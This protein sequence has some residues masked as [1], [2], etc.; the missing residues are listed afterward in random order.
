MHEGI[1]IAASAGIKQ[2]KKMEVIANNLANVNSTGYKKDRLAFKEL[3]PPFPPDTE[4][5]N[6]KNA[7]LPSNKSNKNV[8][9]V[10]VTDQYTDH[11]P[12]IFKQTNSELDMALDGDGYFSISTAEGVLYTRNGNFRLDTE[13]QLVNQKGEPVLNEQGEPIVITA[14]GS[15]IS[16]DANGNIFVGSGLANAN[17][18][19]IKMVNFENKQTLEK[20]GDG[21]FYQSDKE[22][23]EKPIDNTKLRQGFLEGSN[24]TAVEEMTN[25][26]STLRLFETYQ[27]MIQSIDSMD[28]QSVNK[29]GRIG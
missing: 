11:K 15:D 4:M 2:G 25:M 10:A 24:V 8:S 22:A 9:Y 20:I 5:E 12:G 14:Q 18:G 26:I 16:I 17:I 1:Y 29:I 27:K 7:L 19:K 23:V 21:L 28:D 6:T 13:N 3:M